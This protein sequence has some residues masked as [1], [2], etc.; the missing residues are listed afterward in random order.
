MDIKGKKHVKYNGQAERQAAIK[1][2]V[3]GPTHVPKQE[4][5]PMLNSL[6]H[7]RDLRKGFDA[8]NVKDYYY[9]FEPLEDCVLVKILDMEEKKGEIYMSGKTNNDFRKC[10]ICRLSEKT[11]QERPELK[12]GYVVFIQFNTQWLEHKDANAVDFKIVYDTDIKGIYLT[13]IESGDD[14][15]I[16]QTTETK[17]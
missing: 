4:L 11:K 17:K 16:K 9:D 8:N 3:I 12:L 7:E 10:I 1:R 15:E 2:R 5:M 6:E 13:G 14:A